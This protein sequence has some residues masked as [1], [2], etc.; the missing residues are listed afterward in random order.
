MSAVRS[1]RAFLSLRSM[2]TRMCLNMRVCPR[3]MP[4]W[5]RPRCSVCRAIG[6]GKRLAVRDFL[7]L[8]GSCFCSPPAR[9]RDHPFVDDANQR[10]ENIAD[11]EYAHDPPPIDHRQRA[12]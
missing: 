4:W 10:L 11:G 7:I 12:D 5:A 9:L 1:V 8:S 6:G 3:V 2:G